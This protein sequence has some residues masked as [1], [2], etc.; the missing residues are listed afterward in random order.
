MRARLGLNGRALTTLLFS[1]HTT[2][3]VHA[4][5]EPMPTPVMGEQLTPSRTSMPW[6]T[7]LSSPRSWAP[8]G[9]EDCGEVARSS[10]CRARR[11]ITRGACE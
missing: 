5:P 10:Q 6:M 8:A 4:F 7:M 2:F 3:A 9:V 1:Q 11:E